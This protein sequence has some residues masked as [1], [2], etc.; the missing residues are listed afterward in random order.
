MTLSWQPPMT[1][2]EKRRAN[3]PKTN[4]VAARREILSAVQRLEEEPEHVL[5]VKRLA[6]QLFDELIDWHHLGDQERLL[7]EAAAALHDIGWGVARDG[8]NHHKQSA[9]L[10]REQTWKH[11]TGDE[12]NLIA[13]IARYHRKSPPKSK[14]TDFAALDKDQ[15]RIVRTL[16]AL[17][18]VADGLDRRHLQLVR[19]VHI[20]VRES[21]VVFKLE[22]P[23]PVSVE[24]AAGER[25]GDLLRELIGR[26]LVFEWGGVAAVPEWQKS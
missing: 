13:Q 21:A 14:H 5:H 11:F 12:V 15:K 16:S 10:I 22:A 8:A 3:P 4:S 2:Q 9:R 1:T 20:R 6:L 17:L 18:R 7:L 23:R 19:E 24:K 26:K 25:K